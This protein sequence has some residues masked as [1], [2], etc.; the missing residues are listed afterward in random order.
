M[1]GDITSMI[2]ILNNYPDYYDKPY[3][4]ELLDRMIDNYIVYIMSRSFW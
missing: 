1:D 4:V 3:N 2:K